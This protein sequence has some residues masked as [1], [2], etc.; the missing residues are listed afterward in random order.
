MAS[1]AGRVIRRFALQSAARDLLPREA[2]AKCLRAGHPR[3]DGT[4]GVD[5]FYAPA[6]SA[7][8][9]GG[10]QLCKSVWLC[11]VCAAKISERRRVELA[12]A[13]RTWSE[14]ESTEQRRLLLTTFTLQHNR[15][16]ELSVIFEGLKRARR[17]LVSGK[18]AQAF[19]ASYGIVGMIR[20][21]ELTYG[22][23]GWH[24]HLHVLYFFDRE[25]P[26]LPF[27]SAIKARWGQC[28][29]SAGRYASW[30]HGVDVRFSDSDIADYIAKWGKEPKWTPA[31][32]MTKGVAKI[33]RRGGR[34]ALQLLSDYLD[35]DAAAGRLWVQ[36]AGALKGERQ[37]FWSRGLRERLGL[38]AEKTDE[39]IVEEQEEIAIILAS[40][41][42]GA[43]RV[44]IANDARG[45]LLEVASTGDRDQVQAFLVQ[46]GVGDD[47][48]GRNGAAFRG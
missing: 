39:E 18:A 31:H 42:L 8:H 11:P 32:E 14:Q 27:E 48:I 44:V 23:N 25:V 30:A 45:E 3:S 17:L 7:A 46:L 22:E 21:L 24:P 4:W 41:T 2:V 26:I 33:G 29:E 15:A 28:L 13:L 5:V 16:D 1:D 12:G 35:G 9:L 10:L 43:W 6:K 37:L 36:Y 19:A 47:G 34:T 40:L 20:S 38:V